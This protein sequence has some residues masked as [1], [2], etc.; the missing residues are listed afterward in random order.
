MVYLYLQRLQYY[1]LSILKIL[2]NFFTQDVFLNIMKI[3]SSEKK[4]SLY[5]KTY[6][7]TEL[8][9]EN[10]ALDIKSLKSSSTSFEAQGRAFVKMSKVPF[11][12]SDNSEFNYYL[13]NTDLSSETI[14]EFLELTPEQK[15]AA[16]DIYQQGIVSE[17]NLILVAKKDP[18]I[19]E[20]IVELAQKGISTTYS[21]YVIGSPYNG[22]FFP[23]K[24]DKD[25]LLKEYDKV[26]DI[27]D[28]GADPKTVSGAIA[29]DIEMNKENLS[30]ISY[31]LNKLKSLS[32]SS[33]DEVLRGFDL[34]DIVTD[35]DKYKKVVAL[36]DMGI[37]NLNTAQKVSDTEESYNKALEL[38]DSGYNDEDIAI[39]ATI[40]DKNFLKQ[41]QQLMQKY[42]ISAE[43]AKDILDSSNPNKSEQILSKLIEHNIDPSS[44]LLLDHMPDE[45]LNKLLA[46]NIEPDPFFSYLDSDLLDEVIQLIKEGYSED[47]IIS[48]MDYFNVNN[49]DLK[50]LIS[51]N[52]QLN[53]RF[54]DFVQKSKYSDL[55]NKELDV[56]DVKF[57]KTHAFESEFY[58][59]DEYIRLFLLLKTMKTING[60]NIL[61]NE[62]FTKKV[63]E[64]G[65]DD[66]AAK[67]E[68]MLYKNI[69]SILSIDPKSKNADYIKTILK[70]IR[71][72]KVNPSAFR[73]LSDLN[74]LK[75]IDSMLGYK[76]D[77]KSNSSGW[78][79]S[80]NLIND[81][82]LI[83]N[84]DINSKNYI[85]KYIPTFKNEQEGI[86][87]VEIGDAF[88]L[89]DEKHIRI[90]TDEDKSQTVE[91]TKE[92][93]AKLFPPV[94]RFLTTQ[95]IM[96]NC[97][98]IETIM[99]MYCNDATRINLLK[100][101]KE[102]DEGNITIKMGDYNPVVFKDGKLP[103]NEN[104]QIYSSGAQGYKLFEYAYSCALV[105]DKIKETKENLEGE[106]LA[107]FSDFIASN[108]DNFFIY[109]DN[110][111]IK[112]ITYKEALNKGLYKKYIINPLF[113]ILPYK[114]FNN[115]LLGNG[116]FQNDVYNKLGYKSEMYIGGELFSIFS[117][118]ELL[119]QLSA[120]NKKIDN[121]STL[122]K[123]G[124]LLKQKD[125]LKNH[126]V[127]IGLGAHAYNLTKETTKDGNSA[128]FLYNPHNQGFPIRFDDLDELLSK[129]TTVTIVETN[130]RNLI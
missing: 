79:I 60:E 14:N 122:S 58:N 10:K 90:K 127:Q 5:L 64:N 112:W 68:D 102:D 9:K 69:E 53:S 3:N 125:F 29:Y 27:I 99:S 81:I 113:E 73:K 39:L 83:T 85:D 84:K 23:D 70:L 89:E 25:L 88:I 40:D 126:Q 20:K 6:K 57:L 51:N 15:T 96:G 65:Q 55:Y 33:F 105:E 86:K 91:L 129:T 92:T 41:I 123:A 130:E 114:T 62:A 36:F 98:C 18:E 37:K 50:E 22:E 2:V 49:E 115:L 109:K 72:G 28:K 111:E 1:L 106:K 47:E 101:M 93:Y 117:K 12:G 71:I 76:V 119:N 100:T 26:I 8:P 120:V 97:Y 56:K 17:K 38:L 4:N 67:Q 80:N 124:R 30:K 94:E 107:Q 95:Q 78:D 35:D 42:S 31:I 16:L 52:K 87:N 7:K 44:C 121:I 24:Y 48:V 45:S 11:K 21:V 66:F 13:T 82:E 110:N 32:G 61:S 74:D 116:G 34:P 54:S 63:K 103:Q 128:Y 108:P 77:K 118:K 75:S 46:N 19:R 43:L 104:P 59:P